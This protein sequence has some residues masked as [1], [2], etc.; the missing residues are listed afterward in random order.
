MKTIRVH[1]AKPWGATT[2]EAVT[3]VI[4]DE[5]PEASEDRQALDARAIASA[6]WECLPGGT[7]DR[8]CGELLQRQASRLLVARR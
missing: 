6:L 7:L 8:L 4:E 2:P 3:I 5:I 1:K